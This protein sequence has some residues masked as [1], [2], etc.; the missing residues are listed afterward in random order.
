LKI[1]QYH[2]HQIDEI[3]QLYTSVFT[4]S[5]GHEEGLHVGELAYNILS[6]T[7]D[8]DFR[9]FIAVSNKKIIGSVI[10]ST[11]WFDSDIEAFLLSPVA[12]DTGHQGKGI[13]Q[14]LIGSAI[15]SL[16]AEGVE[17]VL[18]Y[19]DPG[20]YSKVGF[21][22]LAEDVIKPPFELTHPEGWL[23]QSLTGNELEPVAGIA[24]CV[25]ALNN[26]DYW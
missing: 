19:G 16:K 20:Y 7:D 17:L 9:C 18:T 22:P 6:S 12:I 23:G 2:Q 26:S 5:E 15:A 24:R 25:E 11:V 8:R 13:G 10:L 14:K 21:R 1:T 3:R 4:H